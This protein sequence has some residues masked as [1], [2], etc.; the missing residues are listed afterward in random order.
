MD[1]KAKLLLRNSLLAYNAEKDSRRTERDNMLG[2]IVTVLA[3]LV[4][5]CFAFCYAD[6][7]STHR[8]KND[9]LFFLAPKY[10]KHRAAGIEQKIPPQS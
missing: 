7:S 9:S 3:V 6:N 2:I 5:I 10:I 8:A 1:E 4:V